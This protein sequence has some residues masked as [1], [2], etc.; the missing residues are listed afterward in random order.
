MV[1]CRSLRALLEDVFA[2]SSQ[3]RPGHEPRTVTTNADRAAALLGHD[4]QK[5]LVFSLF[6]MS[7]QMSEVRHQMSDLNDQT[8][9]ETVLA[10]APLPRSSSA[11]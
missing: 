1:S 9:I 11:R 7:S 5:R 2:P 3:R 6:T 10:K 4:A 8:N